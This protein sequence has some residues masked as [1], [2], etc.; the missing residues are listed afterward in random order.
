MIP[1]PLP[2]S[3]GP[4]SGQMP[5]NTRKHVHAERNVR[6]VPLARV[7]PI[8]LGCHFC[9]FDVKTR[10]FGH[11][12]NVQFTRLSCYEPE[13]TRLSCLELEGPTYF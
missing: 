5:T 4:P 11:T 3:H 10:M 7:S 2:P 9:I 1:P 6:F 13:G 8:A 12:Q